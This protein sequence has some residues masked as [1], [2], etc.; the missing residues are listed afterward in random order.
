MMQVYDFFANL[1]PYM[2]ITSFVLEVDAGLAMLANHYVIWCAGRT[3]ISKNTHRHCYW[4][5]K[6]F[7]DTVVFQFLFVISKLLYKGS[8]SDPNSIF[9]DFL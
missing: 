5:F 6:T 1:N 4:Q 9:F 2:K 3:W 8:Y 7:F